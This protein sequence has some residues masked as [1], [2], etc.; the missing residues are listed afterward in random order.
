MASPVPSQRASWRRPIAARPRSR[1]VDASWWA[2]PA[3]P[4]PAAA[5]RDRGGA[6]GVRPAHAG[7]CP[8]ARVLH[9][10]VSMRSSTKSSHN[11]LSDS[12]NGTPAISTLSLTISTTPGNHTDR[13][14]STIRAHTRSSSSSWF[15]SESVA[16]RSTSSSLLL[17]V[18]AHGASGGG[19][20]RRRWKLAITVSRL[21]ARCWST[22]ACKAP[23]RKS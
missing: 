19:S 9:S 18:G 8:S 4:V 14:R 13:T 21:E 12:L 6:G 22:I 3:A 11:V 1:P 7:T 15:F 5:A 20:A 2:A 16:T 23:I 17:A 10:K